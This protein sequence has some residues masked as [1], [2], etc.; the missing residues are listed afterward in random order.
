MSNPKVPTTIVDKNGKTTTVHKN[1]D[2]GAANK[3]TLPSASAPTRKSENP[4]ISVEGSDKL[5]DILSKLGHS[6]SG[7][8]KENFEAS[9]LRAEGTGG[10]YWFSG[11]K[12]SFKLLGTGAPYSPF[13]I[14]PSGYHPHRELALVL[15]EANQELADAQGDTRPITKYAKER[16]PAYHSEQEIVFSD[17]D[18]EVR[19]ESIPSHLKVYDDM[20]VIVEK[21]NDGNYNVTW[22]VIDDDGGTS[23]EWFEGD[24]FETFGSEEARDNYIE[25][26][27]TDGVPRERIFIVDKYD[28]SSVHYSVANSV[29]YADRRWDVAPSGVLVV[30]EKGENGGVYD[31][32]YANTILQEYSDWSNGDTYGMVRGVYDADGEEVEETEAIWGFIGSD[33]ARRT[34]ENGD[35]F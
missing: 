8:A 10:E 33:Y 1:V 34:L 22:A 11:D 25:S 21:R 15:D 6:T 17:G 28:H 3:R 9:T 7:Y 31:A 12:G 4:N 30:D 16:I 14:I 23:Y 2:K 29:P 5:F 18:N 35:A 32:E 19:I 13:S 24:S 26:K 27:V 20:P